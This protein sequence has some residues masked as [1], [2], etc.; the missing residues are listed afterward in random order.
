ME[1]KHP[2]AVRTLAEILESFRKPVPPQ[3]TKTKTLKGNNIT[4][5]PWYNYIK[6]L[7]RYAPGFELDFKLS[8]APTANGGSQ[9]LATATLTIHGTD[10]SITRS[11][12]GCERSE[13]EK[14]T[15]PV[16]NARAQALR[17]VCA[18]FMLGIDLWKK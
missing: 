1:S 17:K 2:L 3:A 14:F 9:V 11:D 5:I 16:S 10:G 4:F 7:D 15:D 12:V 6:M 18:S 8:Y 13:M